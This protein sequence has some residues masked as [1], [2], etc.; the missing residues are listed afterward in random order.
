MACHFRSHHDWVIDLHLC[1]YLDRLCHGTQECD[2]FQ[3]LISS[4]MWSI[5][6]VTPGRNSLFENFELDSLFTYGA[7]I[8]F[9]LEFGR[10][11]SLIQFLLYTNFA[12]V[13][14]LSLIA[15]LRHYTLSCLELE[16]TRLRKFP[17]PGHLCLRG[18]FQQS[19]A[20]IGDFSSWTASHQVDEW[21]ASN[22]LIMVVL[23]EPEQYPVDLKMNLFV[24]Y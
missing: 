5:L 17:S 15:L 2:H 16:S 8:G 21:A 1:C 14:V 23:H 11:S 20:E 19:V 10:C 9:R 3:I 6:D 22:D 13:T 18:S 24:V 4:Y 7:L 12:Q